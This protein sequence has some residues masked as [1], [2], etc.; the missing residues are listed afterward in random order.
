MGVA[1]AHARAGEPFGRSV[2]AHE[3]VDD[4]ALDEVPALCQ[5]QH[6]VFGGDDA[7]LVQG[8]AGDRGRGGAREHGQLRDVGG[9][10]VDVAQQPT[11]R[12]LGLLLEQPVAG[13]G[14]HHRVEHD[15]GGGRAVEELV[16]GGGRILGGDS[17]R[18]VPG[19]IRCGRVT[20]AQSLEP[21]GDFG[22]DRSVEKHADLDRVDGDVVGNR[23][24]L[25][26]EEFHGRHVDVTD[27]PRVLADQ[28]GDHAHAV[29]A[30]RGERLQVGL[31]PGAAGGVGAGD[32]Q[33]PR[34]PPVP[35]GAAC[36]AASGPVLGELR[37]CGNVGGAHGN[38]L[39]PASTGS[40][41]A[42]VISA[43]I[44]PGTP[45]RGSG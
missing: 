38:I 34:D 5:H 6:V 29:G 23:V 10:Q 41:S 15:D 22:D 13:G 27:A 42:G 25:R 32:G 8:L 40:S 26:A 21:I 17:G 14:H 9:D 39:P 11:Q 30:V 20:A 44:L 19:R 2:G 36:D 16:V 37:V 18:R 33:H 45:C 31:Q 43:R 1:G 28:C 12:V 24:Q 3:G 7:R 4:F 35:S